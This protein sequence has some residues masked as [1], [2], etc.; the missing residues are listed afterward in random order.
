[1]SRICQQALIH[2]V[3]QKANST[4]WQTHFVVQAAKSEGNVQ[5][6]DVCA[7]V[8]VCV[9]VCAA[10]KE[11]KESVG[12]QS[13]GISSLQDT[14]HFCHGGGESRAFPGC[15]SNEASLFYY[16]PSSPPWVS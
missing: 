5:S 2:G 6:P 3:I 10:E 4:V 7:C 9:R 16:R 1:M 11:P 15:P 13:C 14:R 12:S 8:C